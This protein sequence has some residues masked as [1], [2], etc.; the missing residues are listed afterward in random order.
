MVLTNH[1]ISIDPCSFYYLFEMIYIC[2]KWYTFSDWF[3]DLI[4]TVTILV[5]RY[6]VNEI[7]K[8]F[9]QSNKCW[10]IFVNDYSYIYSNLHFHQVYHYT[11]LVYSFSKLR[12]YFRFTLSGRNHTLFIL[13]IFHHPSISNVQHFSRCNKKFRTYFSHFYLLYCVVSSIIETRK[14]RV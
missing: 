6:N 7:S 12:F 8:T 1:D 4:D 9:I 11:S 14:L 2:S 13:P 3:P 10:H 5:S